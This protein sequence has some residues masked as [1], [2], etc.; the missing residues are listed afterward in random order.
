M[1]RLIT[2][3]LLFATT[4]SF[5]ACDKEQFIAESKLPAESRAFLKT[6]FDGVEVLR[7]VKEIDGL[8]KDYSVYL[9]NGFEVDFRRSGAWDQVEGHREALPESIIG[10]L[11]DG[12]PAFVAENYPDHP[13]V[14]VNR[15]HWGYEIELGRISGQ[16]GDIELDFTESGEFF[17]YD[18]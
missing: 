3:A 18:D 9:K 17:R 13:I 7:A 8:E 15:E 10:I 14:K 5:A 6:H 1:K 11:P 12:I 2:I 16:G 4:A